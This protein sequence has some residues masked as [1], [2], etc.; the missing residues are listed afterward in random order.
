MSKKYIVMILVYGSKK[1]EKSIVM[2]VYTL[3]VY[4]KC[5]FSRW[6]TEWYLHSISLSSSNDN[7]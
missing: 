1:N 6:C 3:F 2:Y 7:D 5:L 4:L